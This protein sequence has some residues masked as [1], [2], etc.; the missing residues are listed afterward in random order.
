[1]TLRWMLGILVM[2]IAVAA[3]GGERAWPFGPRGGNGPRVLV[4][5]GGGGQ[6][7]RVVNALARAGIAA[8]IC[9]L[10]TVAF[11]PEEADG[12]RRWKAILLGPLPLGAR[13]LTRRQMQAMADYVRAGGGMVLA[14]GGDGFTGRDGHGGYRDT[15]LADIMPVALR[16]RSD[17][18]FRRE[19]PKPCAEHPVLAGLPPEWP[20]MGERNQARAKQ[21]ATV[22][23]RFRDDPLL[24]VG[25]AGKGRAAALLTAWGW[26]A[27]LEFMLWTGFPRLWANLCTWAG[28]FE[29]PGKP[30]D[31]PL[32]TPAGAAFGYARPGGRPL[33]RGPDGKAAYAWGTSVEVRTL[34]FV[35]RAAREWSFN[36]YHLWN[37]RPQVYAR[38]CAVAQP[39]GARLALFVPQNGPYARF[40]DGSTSGSHIPYDA[41]WHRVPDFYSPEWQKAFREGLRRIAE[42][43]EPYR[44]TVAILWVTNEPEI[45]KAWHN[46]RGADFC[47]NTPAALAKA[48]EHATARYQTVERLNAAWATDGGHRYA[49]ASW[50]DFQKRVLDGLMADDK[51]GRIGPE[52][53]RWLLDFVCTRWLADWHA[54]VRRLLRE[55]G[56]DGPLLGVRHNYNSVPELSLLSCDDLDI[57]GKNLYTHAW[58][59]DYV[60][61]TWD[62]FRA[63]GLPVL[64]SEWG[65]Q[66]AKRPLGYVGGD[67]VTRAEQAVLGRVL[68]ARCPWAVGDVWSNVLDIDFPWGFLWP[69]GRPKPFVPLLGRAAAVPPVHRWSPL[70]P[71]DY[72]LAIGSFEAQGVR[73]T[74]TKGAKDREPGVVFEALPARSGTGAGGPRTKGGDR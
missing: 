51:E 48:R 14:G 27:Q 29:A 61:E 41:P 13:N 30:L 38:A 5:G 17:H 69:N 42:A 31:L 24:V 3:A 39:V 28:R 33:L 37:D 36:F 26:P 72:A 45:Y 68:T 55:E 57:F 56:L 66:P 16:P 4:I 60:F 67:E 70:R 6:V 74:Q 65:V 21:D 46:W 22:L 40:H 47:V 8:D 71:G 32:G 53:H 34:D 59:S 64:S 62:A 1:V 9:G 15:P 58:S 18:L 11:L 50:D 12:Y 23:V 10:P 52:A 54:T 63:S 44:D 20:P 25:E 7:A 35:T 19:T 43:V 49:F 73:I 2:A